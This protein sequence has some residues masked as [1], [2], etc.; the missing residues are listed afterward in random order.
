MKFT[1]KLRKDFFLKNILFPIRVMNGQVEGNREYCNV[2]NIVVV[3][4]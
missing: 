1:F 4:T 3:R 2:F